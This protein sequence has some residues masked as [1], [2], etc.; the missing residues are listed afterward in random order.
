MQQ[1][2]RDIPAED[3]QML[4]FHPSTVFTEAAKMAGYDE[5]TLPWVDGMYQFNEMVNVREAFSNQVC[6]FRECAW[7][8]RSLGGIFRG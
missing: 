7:S 6:P 8:I 4:S 5:N 2:A 3:M 1:I